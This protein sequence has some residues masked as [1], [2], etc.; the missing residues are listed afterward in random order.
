MR[1]GSALEVFHLPVGL[2]SFGG[3]IRTRK[4]L[5]QIGEAEDNCSAVVSL[6]DTDIFEFKALSSENAANCGAVVCR[7]SD[8]F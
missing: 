2:T 1:E 6:K 4:E 5:S 7:L 3:P 8:G